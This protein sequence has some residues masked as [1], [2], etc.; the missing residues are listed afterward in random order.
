MSAPAI[1][2]FV[3]I[4]FV[5]A[6]FIVWLIYSKRYQRASQDS[7]FVRTGFGG[8]RIVMSGGALV[9][10]VLHEVITVNMGTMRLDI[11]RG[12]NNA[13][14]TKDHM[15]MNVQAE[16]YIRVKPSPEDIAMA[17]Q[18][19]GRKTMNPDAL[20]S[21]LQGKFVNILHAVAAEMNMTE[22]H[23]NRGVYAKKVQEAVGDGLVP[24]GLE[25]ESVS[26]SELVQTDRKFFN[27]QNA[28]DAEGLM[29]LTEIIQGR[30]KQRNAIERDTEVAI[31]KKD[32]EAER[33]KLIL[34]KEEEFARLAQ[35][36]EISVRRAE[37][38]AL[39]ISQ[40]VENERQA[41]QAELLA[42]QQVEEIQLQTEKELEEKRIAKEQALKE[43]EISRQRVLEAAEI[44]R[45]QLIEENRIKSN[46]TIKSTQIAAEQANRAEQ[47]A[48][49]QELEQKEIEKLKY[50]EQLRIDKDA[51]LNEKE[52]ELGRQINEAKLAAEQQVDRHRIKLEKELQEERIQ[53]EQLI[54]ELEIAKA[55]LL[56]I[57]EIERQKNNELAEMGRLI[58]VLEKTK[59][60][61]LAQTQLDEARVN[62]IKAE[63]AAQTARQLE[64][65]Q[66]NKAVEIIDAEKAVQREALTITE[67]A[68]A[69]KKEASSKA[70]AM[71]IIAQGEAGKIRAIAEAE[72]TADLTKAKASEERYRVDAAGQRALYEAENVL[73]PAKSA[74]RIKMAVIENMAEIVRQSVKPLK[75]ID[76]IKIIQVDGLPG[77]GSGSGGGGSEA[78]GGGGNLADQLVNSA[79][80][81]RGQ[82][83]LLDSVLKEVGLY[84]GSV[85]GLTA[86]LNDSNDDDLEVGDEAPPKDA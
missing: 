79:L 53:K 59:E 43:R 60:Q 82:A 5:I 86:P 64:I 10:P 24:N 51:F 6:C 81:Y 46:Q 23:Q 13:V 38:Q 4:V 84:G 71:G 47:L 67:M 54:Q 2:F 35:E 58:A 73:D 78:N 30:A 74:S 18:T 29:K 27:P 62:A 26:I 33:E 28:F 72:A 66:R 42:K 17:A 32:L 25:L 39:I 56:E 77:S 16:F 19:L 80:R 85:K 22:L 69:R 68:E 1:L 83:P 9:F 70:E 52:I 40:K 11:A 44:E 75:S 50:L 8:R 14:V 41:R 57:A 49:D 63:E 21:L 61:V 76:G 34:T 65:A 37:Q 20:K 48:K 12:D 45:E 7:A 31:K 55:K 3:S 15:R 36:Q